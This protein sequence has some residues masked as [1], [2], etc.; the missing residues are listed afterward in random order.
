MAPISLSRSDHKAQILSEIDRY[1]G[2]QDRRTVPLEPL[3]LLLAS[4][5]TYLQGDDDQDEF[6]HVDDADLIQAESVDQT[7]NS[8]GTKRKGSP[9]FLD[10]FSPKKPNLVDDPASIQLAETILQKTWGFPH[11][12]LKQQQAIARLIGGGSAVVIFPTGGGKSL[13]Y[14]IPALAFDEYDAQCGQTPGQGVT[15]VVSPLIALMK[16]SC[17]RYPRSASKNVKNLGAM[18]NI[19]RLCNRSSP[20]NPGSSG[21]SE[22]ARGLRC[23][24]GLKPKSRVVA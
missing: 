17:S 11:F 15:L 4:V 20:K 5:S 3:Q 13:V 7:S 8:P 18:P 12:R 14:Q 22:K 9:G 1:R 6:G 23:R 21:R 19:R 16:V 10:Q 2:I 24:Y